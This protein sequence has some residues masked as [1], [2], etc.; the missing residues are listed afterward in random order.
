[1]A[2]E[3]RPENRTSQAARPG[4]FI[5]KE[6]KKEEIHI[7]VCSLV[8]GVRITPGKAPNWTPTLRF[9]YAKISSCPSFCIDACRR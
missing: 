5:E 9:P 8:S 1:M 2:I 7:F 3:N 6:E 4:M